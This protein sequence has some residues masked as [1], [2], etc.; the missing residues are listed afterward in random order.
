[1]TVNRL[2]R[3]F[4]KWAGG[5]R[6]LVPEILQYVP[7]KYGTYYEPFIGGGAVLFALQPSKAV[8]NDSNHELT[9]CYEVIRDSVEDLIEKLKQHRLANCEDYYYEIRSIDRLEGY[10]TYSQIEKAARI[11][12]LNKTCYNGLFR[13]NSQGQF[14]VPF[15]KYENPSILD[16]AVLRGVS[17]YLKQ[18]KIKIIN[19]DFAE[20]TITAKKGDFIYFDPP[21]DPISST[22]SFTGYDVN[23][24]DKREQERLKEVID[25][26]GNRGCRVL[27]SNS[28]TDFIVDL[29]RN[30]ELYK[31]EVVS[32]TRAINSNALKRGQVDEVLIRNYDL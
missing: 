26:L 16:E 6:Q 25:N 4:L 28:C 22:A 10:D 12:Y 21:Y 27:L 23:G 1:V 30:I 11:L 20:A 9:N 32:A 17:K 19:T 15:G 7:K 8:I 13:V 14:N 5:K 29:Y 18:K 2:V 24:F 3:P 31:I